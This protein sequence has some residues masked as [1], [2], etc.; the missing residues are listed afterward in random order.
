MRVR[1][2]RV[3][4]HIEE[5]GVVAKILY[6]VKMRSIELTIH[7]H[8]GHNLAAVS[9]L[10]ALVRSSISRCHARK[11][12]AER[13]EDTKTRTRGAAREWRPQ[14]RA[15][16]VIGFNLFRTDCS[17]SGPWTVPLRETTLGG[18]IECQRRSEGLVC[19]DRGPV[20]SVA[21]FV[22]T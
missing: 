2:D 10:G 6:S 3:N 7:S 4:L 13:Y 12:V 19:L 17:A 20:R 21:T 14:S 16:S 18:R 22:R 8:L 15:G 1:R 9:S 5:G 11:I